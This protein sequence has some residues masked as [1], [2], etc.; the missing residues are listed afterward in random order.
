MRLRVRL[1][2]GRTER[3]ATPEVCSLAQLRALLVS[4]FTLTT[5]PESVRLSLNGRDEL[6][7]PGESQLGAAGFTDGDLVY[8]LGG[9]PASVSAQAQPAAAPAPAGAAQGGAAAE[10][11]AEARRERCAASLSAEPTAQEAPADPVP[12]ALR[13][14]LAAGWRS[15]AEALALLLHAAMQDASFVALPPSPAPAR[16]RYTYALPGD[17]R[18]AAWLRCEALGGELVSYAAAEGCDA[19]RLALS[20]A[21]AQ[22]AAPPNLPFLHLRSLWAAAKDALA[23]R[24]LRDA[25]AA[26]GRPQLAPGLLSLPD[27]VKALA[28]GRL[29]ARSLAAAACVCRE[30][31]F[32]AADEALWAALYA[33]EFARAAPPAAARRGARAAFAAAWEERERERRRAAMAAEMR[34]RRPRPHIFPVQQGAPPGF[35]PIMPPGYQPGIIGGDYDLQPGGFGA[36]RFQPPGGFGFGPLGPFPPG[37]GGG[38]FGGGLGRGG[39]GL[40]PRRD[41]DREPF[42]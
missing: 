7:A 12:A 32:A 24:A 36:N 21:H 38:M 41:P 31:R 29:D 33:S 13:A 22:Q 30:L 6:A 16:P 2:P 35:V 26:A 3:V 4:R 5:P 14:A 28:L 42:Q 11:S 23:S 15:P 8:V 37:P 9:H 1:G 39:M 10:E 17:P 19:H 18:P 25:L 27:H 20:C 40:P 34:R